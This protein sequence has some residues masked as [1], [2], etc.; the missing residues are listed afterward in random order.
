MKTEYIIAYKNNWYHFF[1]KPNLG[2]CTSKKTGALFVRNEVLLANPF[3]DFCVTK[4][5]K[6]IHAV[7]QDSFGSIIYFI[8]DG[9]VWKSKTILN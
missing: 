2:F 5:D 8:F 4:T 9:N 1:I 6:Y 7:C 3:E